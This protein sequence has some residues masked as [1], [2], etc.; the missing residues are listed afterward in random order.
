[1]SIPA[2]LTAAL[3]RRVSSVQVSQCLVTYVGRSDGA[4]SGVPMGLFAPNILEVGDSDRLSALVAPRPL[5]I[6][7]GVEPEG[8]TVSKARLES[9]FAFTRNVYGLLGR[10]E[11]FGLGSE[12]DSL[13]AP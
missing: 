12:Q 3:D 9:A 8:E 13:Q 11:W 1:M 10:S 6:A 7:S 2:I 5:S 4:W